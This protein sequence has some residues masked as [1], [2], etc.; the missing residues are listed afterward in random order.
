MFKL[1]RKGYYLIPTAEVPVT[2]IYRNEVLNETELP[3][4]MTAYTPC[5]RAEAGSAGRDTRGLIRNHQFD[6]VEMVMYSTPEDSY[7]QLE[8]LTG[9]AEEILKGLGL[10]Y[11]VVELCTGDVGFSSAKTYDLEVWMPSY[12]KYVEIS[13]CSNF[14]DFQARRA[15]IRYR[16]KDRGKLEFIHTLNGSGLA[17]GRTFAAVLENYQNEDGAVTVPEV[18]RPYMRGMKK[19]SLKLKRG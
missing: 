4:Y 17:V 15:N 12:S 10:P 18:L 11:R 9:F 13:S 19:I 7:R 3:M 8:I 14:E 2:N 16:T 5:F 1:N 6:K